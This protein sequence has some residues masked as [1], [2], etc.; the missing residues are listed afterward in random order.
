M[1]E[2]GLRSA[3][4]PVSARMPPVAA[5]SGGNDKLLKV[6]T[7]FATAPTFIQYPEKAKDKVNRVEAAKHMDML[8]GLYAL[9]DN[10]QF[11]QAQMEYVFNVIFKSRNI[12]WQPRLA[13]EHQTNWAN[14]IAKR[15]RTLLSHVQA[16]RRKDNKW[17]LVLL[18]LAEDNGDEDDGQQ[19]DELVETGDEGSGGAA[20]AGAEEPASVVEEAPREAD[21]PGEDEADGEALAAPESD[22]PTAVGSANSG[23]GKEAEGA[24]TEGVENT[25]N[26]DT[27]SRLPYVEIMSNKK[28][29]KVFGEWLLPKKTDHWCW[30]KFEHDSSKRKCTEIVPQELYEILKYDGQPQKRVC[31]VLHSS[32]KKGE[33]TT[34]DVMKSELKDKTHLKELK[35][36]LREEGDVKKWATYLVF[37]ITA[38]EDGKNKK[39]QKTQVLSKKFVEI[40]EDEA[41]GRDAALGVAVQCADKLACAGEPMTNKEIGA[42][43]DELIADWE[44][45]N[46]KRGCA[47]SGKDPETPQK[48][49]VPK[50]AQPKE[51]KTKKAD[52]AVAAPSSGSSASQPA[53]SQGGDGNGSGDSMVMDLTLDMWD[54]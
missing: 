11:S 16:A 53:P 31:G 30:A 46:D 43:K 21:C 15:V 40:M 12:H 4:P 44:G 27:E 50:E 35:D 41:S 24:A 37:E 33:T 3:E 36:G 52:G 34:Y 13:P 8:R 9:S 38:N 25:C 7:P 29:S 26:Y 14:T 45:V 42:F 49:S 51:A 20:I 18:G 39:T 6:L 19:E 22:I 54:F 28:R 2:I 32:Q 5:W 47:D 17:A 10:L 23:V 48:L 1:F